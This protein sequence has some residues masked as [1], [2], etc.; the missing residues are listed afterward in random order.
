MDRV[1][2]S[3]LASFEAAQVRSLR[4][5]LRHA[6][7]T[8]G[9]KV[10]DAKA[11]AVNSVTDTLKQ[12]PEGRPTVRKAARSRSA[13]AALKRLDELWAQ[14]C[15]PTASSL[16]GLLRDARE[17]FYEAS[18]ERWKPFIPPDLRVVSDPAPTQAALRMVRAMP[19]H[20]YDVRQELAVPIER[21]KRSL[22]AAIAQCGQRS[23]PEHVAVDILDGWERRTKSALFRVAQSALSDGQKAAETLAGRDLVHPDYLDELPNP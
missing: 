11:H 20:G 23:T 5:W 13:Q 1:T 19:L 18:H 16:D 14:L 10:S 3:E 22:L 2:T 15:G 21:A 9:T 12:V 7:G 8:I 6:L 17:A 4:P